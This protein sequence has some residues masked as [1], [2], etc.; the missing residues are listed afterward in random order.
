MHMLYM[1]TS[2]SFGPQCK[3][4]KPMKTWPDVYLSA[5]QKMQKT[6]F[7]FF[8]FIF[9]RKSGLFSSKY[10]FLSKTMKKIFMNV[11]CC[12]RDWRFI[13]IQKLFAARGRNTFTVP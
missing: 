7:Y 2:F 8:T 4:I 11:V 6:T 12:S 3:R 5:K 10:N 13:I 1:H 9:R